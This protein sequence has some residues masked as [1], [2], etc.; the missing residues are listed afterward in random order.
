MDFGDG[1]N[2]RNFIYGLEMNFMM[3]GC[4]LRGTNYQ[5]TL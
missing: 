1:G 3:I 5:V 2:S 4:I